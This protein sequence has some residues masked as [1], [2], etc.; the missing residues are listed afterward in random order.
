MSDSIND[1]AIRMGVDA[2]G[3]EAGFRQARN[4]AVDF[5][6]Y[7]QKQQADQVRAYNEANALIMNNYNAH[8]NAHKVAMDSMVRAE[9]EAAAQVAK[10]RSNNFMYNVKYGDPYDN[11]ADRAARRA[12]QETKRLGDAAV[13]KANNDAQ[14]EATALLQKHASASARAAEQIRRLDSL[15][16]QY[17]ITTGKVMITDAQYSNIR[18]KIIMQTIRQQ[19]AQRAANQA[20]QQGADTG[21]VMTGVLAQASFAAEDFIQGIAFGDLR[22]ALLGAS[23]NMTMVVRGLLQVG[24]ESGGVAAQLAGMVK[25]LIGIP[26]A[27][28]GLVAAFNWA[29]YAAMDVRSLSEA[30]GDAT[31]GLKAFDNARDLKQNDLQFK[32]RLRDMD[33]S[34][35][36]EKERLKLQD[37]LT[38]KELELKD[39]RRKTNMEAEAFLQNQ[40]GGLDATIELERQIAITKANGTQEEIAAANRLQFLMAEVRQNY[41]EGEAENA[42]RNMREMFNI[43]NDM[44]LVDGAEWI[45]DLTALDAL[46]KK[47]NNEWFGMFGQVE[48][49]ENLREIREQLVGQGEELSKTDRERL[50]LIDQILA[51]EEAIGKAR[52]KEAAAFAERVKVQAEAANLQREE[53]LLMIRATD[54]Q[55]TLLEMR[56]EQKEFMGPRIAAVDPLMQMVLDAQQQ[57]A[58]IDFLMAQ[59]DALL[60]EQAKQFS[61]PEI[62]GGLMQNAFDAQAEA[63]KQ[64]NAAASKRPDPQIEKTNELLR[65]IEEAIKNGGV[66]KVVP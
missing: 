23:N 61:S 64:M 31:L 55:K 21:R 52:D 20:M 40:L 42:I 7:I 51:V 41:R 37:D 59:K 18:T 54:A 1:I 17:N 25:Y 4:A 63:F 65:K 10:I 47:F 33:D 58:G 45:G 62:K 9:T 14:A 60:A 39:L 28:G 53:T 44:S 26:V 3:V 48:S 57:Q 34:N 24:R 5:S 46:E 30:L 13:M 49:A 27:A 36:L 32:R 6:K 2:G 11:P 43:L 12:R 16:Q 35:A 15:Y 29:R 56:K 8:V 19:Q 38:I 66:L 22:N 50:Q